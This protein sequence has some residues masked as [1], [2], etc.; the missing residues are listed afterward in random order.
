MWGGYH[1]INTKKTHFKCRRFVLSKRPT[2]QVELGWS[3][4]VVILIINQSYIWEYSIIPYFFGDD[5]EK[6]ASDCQSGYIDTDFASF[7]T[8]IITAYLTIATCIA[9]IYSLEL[10]HKALIFLFQSLALFIFVT[11]VLMY[12]GERRIGAQGW[13]EFVA[14]LLYIV[15]GPFS[16][17]VLVLGEDNKSIGPIRK[18]EKND[19][20]GAKKHW[21]AMKGAT[22]AAMQ[23]EE[24]ELERCLCCRCIA[25]CVHCL[26]CCS[27]YQCWD[28]CII[29]KFGKLQDDN[30]TVKCCGCAKLPGQNKN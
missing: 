7:K 3:V 24:L 13:Q 17:I 14:I 8:N 18:K 5:E 28:A 11:C 4:A 26:I 30:E 22:M 21:S 12:Y 23:Q 15:F 6:A 27:V 19:K 9:V 29:P 20:K 16:M 2:L 10:K 1:A 25:S